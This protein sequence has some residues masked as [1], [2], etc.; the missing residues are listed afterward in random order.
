LD[1]SLNAAQYPK[2]EALTVFGIRFII[3]GTLNL[4]LHNRYRLESELGQGGMGTVYRA[5]DTLLDR[6]IAIKL[7]NQ[8]NL[9]ADSRERLLREARAAARLN[10]PNIVGIYDV[11]GAD[12]DGGQPFIVME[13]VEGHSLYDRPPETLAEVLAIAKQMCLALDHAHQHGVIHRDLKLENILITKDGS[14]KLTDFGLARSVASRL[15]SEGMLVGTVFYLAPELA[16]GQAYDGRAD[17]YALGVLLY[18][19]T[20]H[21]LPF[22]GDDPLAVISQHLHAPVVPPRAIKPEL[23]PALDALIVNLLAKKPEDRPA[24]A[25]VVKARLDEINLNGN[26]AEPNLENDAHLS[27]LDRIVQGRLIGR[28]REMAEA[29]GTWRRA[30]DGEA[31]LLLIS[32]EPGIGKSRLAR[33]LTALAEVSG[34]TALRGECYA[35]G[36]APYA[37]IAQLIQSSF[38]NMNNS[39]PLS[40]LALADLVTLAPALRARF[41]EARANPALDPQAEQQRIFESVVEWCLSVSGRGPALLLVDDAHW[42]DNGTLALLHHLARRSRSLKLR[43]LIVLTYR[44][45]ELDEHHP[46]N[47]LLA[48]LNRERLTKRIKL[49]RLSREQ[50]AEM[51]NVMFEAAAMPDFLNG[52]YRETEGNPFFVEE[53]C[54]ALVE[55]GQLVFAEGGWQRPNMAEVQVPQSIRLAIQARV[56]K[57]PQAAQD[58]LRLA[59]AFGREFDFD[60]LQRAA[61]LPEDV[62][63]EALEQATRAQLISEQEGKETFA[64]V[65]ALIPAA[66]RDGV[67]GL[68]RHRLHKKVA[69]ALEALRPGDFETLA[70]QYAEAG[71]EEQARTH[72]VRAGARAQ[73]VFANADAIKFYSEALALFAEDDST[74]FEVLAARALVYDVIANRNAQRADGEAMLAIAERLNDNEKRFDAYIVLADVQADSEHI[75]AMEP[76][77][78]ALAIARAI[79]DPVREARALQRIGGMSTMRGEYGAALAALEAAVERFKAVNLKAEAA[80]SLHM[81]SL[82]LGRN[83]QVREARIAVEESIALSRE[84]GD[85]RQEAIGLRRLGIMADI[86]G[87]VEASLGYN[88]QALA[89]HRTLGDRAQEVNA[90]AN[91]SGIYAELGNWDES[92]AYA[93]QTLEVS[94]AIDWTEGIIKGIH[95]I[96]QN[97][98]QPRGD[99]GGGLR[100]VKEQLARTRISDNEQLRMRVRFTER[101]LQSRAGL[102]ALALDGAH[103]DM[104][105]LEQYGKSLVVDIYGFYAFVEA[106]LNLFDQ[107]RQSIAQARAALGEE[108]A[109]HDQANLFISSA[110]VDL[111]AGYAEPDVATRQALWRQSAEGAQK[112]LEILQE[113]KAEGLAEFRGNVLAISGWILTELGEVEE[114]LKRCE[115]AVKMLDERPTL[116]TRAPEQLL[117]G[118]ARALRLTGRKSEANI[119]LQRAYDRYKVVL[120]SLT[121]DAEREG[122]QT[123]VL[124]SRMLLEDVARYLNP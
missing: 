88:N 109:P 4:T 28:E 122:W 31:H 50:T 60:L 89:L 73:Q 123:G 87:E 62:L 40:A 11:G 57:L 77:A 53:V 47:D 110:Y 78:Q 90:L 108:P 72:Y 111:M 105:L 24:T 118:Y 55:D 67:S 8:Q 56:S 19:L 95:E 76:A 2:G 85:R 124:F 23:P 102:S 32:G 38:V 44:E 97:Y 98:Y 65:H 22:D 99:Y 35:E 100:F 14:V 92:L 103:E 34:A 75:R 5:L 71:D 10:H 42:A 30:Q 115:A 64:F 37:P 49:G 91:L 45:T 63:I 112:T 13:M 101:I 114:G 69:M 21:R 41:P 121:D 93:R 43:L 61:E 68:R 94:E 33:E 9:A 29:A 36:G 117:Y 46:L 104:A 59:A 84:T 20:T 74:R 52:I 96:V 48:D 39:L 17:L 120:V 116:W 106:D 51:L 26:Q 107:A 58:A 113:G 7:L 6:A 70:Y 66:L 25:A 79:P 81:L 83:G 82:A 80:S 18:E 54:K 3:S 27:L 15:T 16:L 119:Y 12:D 1:N 86:Q